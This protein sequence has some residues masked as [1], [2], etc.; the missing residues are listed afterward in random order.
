MRSGLT[1]GG[2]A[3]TQYRPDASK[4]KDRQEGLDTSAKLEIGR[5]R[6]FIEISHF[7]E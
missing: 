3:L 7:V 2:F 6:A 4:R 5:Q 1:P